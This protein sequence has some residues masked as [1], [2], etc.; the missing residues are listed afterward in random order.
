MWDDWIAARNAAT[1]KALFPEFTRA[2]DALVL[3]RIGMAAERTPEDIWLDLEPQGHAYLTAHL[4]CMLPEAK[5]LRLEMNPGQS[6]YGVE[7][8]RLAAVVSS[9][10][11][12][13]GV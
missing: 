6:P 13:A 9:G 4:I 5:D 11:R 10:F 2:S 3:S 12:T 8:D 7:R 1:F